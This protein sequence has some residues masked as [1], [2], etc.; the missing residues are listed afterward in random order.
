MR[1]DSPGKLPNFVILHDQLLT[2][3]ILQS[4]LHILKGNTTRVCTSVQYVYT[5]KETA[6]LIIVN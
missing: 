3:L 4:D 1:G 6:Y 5:I 2:L